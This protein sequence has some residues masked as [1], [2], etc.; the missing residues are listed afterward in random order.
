MFFDYFSCLLVLAISVAF[1]IEGLIFNLIRFQLQL[2]FPELVASHWLIPAIVAVSGKEESVLFLY[3]HSM[4]C[5]LNC[6][7][8]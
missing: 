7:I 2:D 1:G 4:C 8:I 6:C 5:F 3:I